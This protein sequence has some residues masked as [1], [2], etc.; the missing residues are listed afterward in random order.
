MSKKKILL[1]KGPLEQSLCSNLLEAKA[2]P[3]NRSFGFHTGERIYLT[4]SYTCNLPV[5][6]FYIYDVAVRTA[7]T[8]LTVTCLI[9]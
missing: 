7:E 8:P 1:V 5:F 2:S 3:N 4:L 9:E 6:C